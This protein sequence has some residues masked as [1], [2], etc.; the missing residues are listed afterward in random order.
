M[1]LKEKHKLDE[2][3]GILWRHFSNKSQGDHH[4]ESGSRKSGQGFS[5]ISIPGK[6]MEQ[7]V[8]DAISTQLEEKKVIRNSQHGFTKGKS[9]LTNLIA[10]YGGITSWVDGGRAVNVVYLD[11]RKVFDTASH[12]ILILK[13]RKHGIDEWMLRWVKNWLTGWAQKV[14]IRVWLKTCD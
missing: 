8:L 10:F 13:L 6:V 2:I 3:K 9:C 5:F 4:N 11:F 12:D 1:I 7:L 14:V